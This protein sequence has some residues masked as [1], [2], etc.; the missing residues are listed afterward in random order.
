MLDVSTDRGY[1]DAKAEYSDLGESLRPAGY[2]HLCF[3]VASVDETLAELERRKVRIVGEAFNLPGI[4]RRLAF[5]ADPWGNLLEL[6]QVLK[7]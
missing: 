3:T 1:S 4:S 7:D 2:H 6:A 5:F